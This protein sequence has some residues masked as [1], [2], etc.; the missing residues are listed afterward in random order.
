[1][2]EDTDISPRNRRQNRRVSGNGTSGFI[3]FLGFIGALIYFIQTATSFTDGL[4]G[5]LQALVWPGVLV[6]KLAEFLKL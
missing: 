1:M 2:A 5:F 4:L 6:Y 3:Y